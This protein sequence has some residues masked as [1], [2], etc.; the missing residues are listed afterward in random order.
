VSAVASGLSVLKSAVADW[1]SKLE[2]L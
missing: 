2:K 1:N